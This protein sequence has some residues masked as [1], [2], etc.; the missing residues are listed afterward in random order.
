M[1]L[2][3]IS[4]T[5]VAATYLFGSLWALA[6]RKVGYRHI[7]HTISEIGEVGSPHQRFVAFGLFLP[8]GLLL[9][10]VGILVHAASP[11]TAALAF[12]IAIGYIIAAAFPCDPGSPF[13]GSTRQAIHN[14]GGAFEYIGG[15]FALMTL[16][17]SH[18]QPFR[19]AGFVVLGAAILLSVLPA[20]SVRGTVQ[21]V[22]EVCLFG[23]LALALWRSG[24]VA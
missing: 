4:L 17:E 11:P 5:V 16:A 22:A 2:L 7:Q 19:A 20:N 1:T 8:I 14:L 23:A 6:P 18:D 24:G 12:C 13:S 10:A 21:R 9:V 3:A 15:A